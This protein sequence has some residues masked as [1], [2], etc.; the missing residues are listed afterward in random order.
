MATENSHF[1]P[2]RNPQV[3]YERSDLSARGIL[4]FLIGLFVV[5][6][7]IELVIWGMFRFLA[8]T[9]VYFEQGK[10][11]P[12]IVTQPAPA[13]APSVLQNTPGVNLHVFPQPRL[14]TN[15]AG[16]MTEY[17]ESEDKLLNTAQPFAESNG[18]I[19][20]PISL[21][22]K[23]IVERGLPVRP[24]A[25]PPDINTQTAAGNT[26]MLDVEAGPLGPSGA[27][28]AMAKGA[29]AEQKQAGEAKP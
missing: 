17:V 22:M 20:L 25:P 12:M 29:S 9:E 28:S 14:Q 8:R 24:N 18:T 6:I 23:E 2:L 5:G 4:G 16:E 3:D 10:K 11:N 7:F 15:D 1:D 27:P 21:A 19:H 13:Q 26:K